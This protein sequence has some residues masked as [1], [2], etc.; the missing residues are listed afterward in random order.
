MLDSNG[1]IV[2]RFDVTVGEGDGAALIESDEKIIEVV[3]LDSTLASR[4]LSL[5]D[6]RHS[7]GDISSATAMRADEVRVISDALIENG[8]AVSAGDPDAPIDHS[9][10]AALA[11]R[12]YP[13]WKRRLFG[14]GLWRSL[15][16]G[17]ATFAQ[18]AG[19]LLENY[20]LIEGV[21]ARL[22]SATAYCNTREARRLFSHHYREEFDHGHFFLDALQKIGIPREQADASLPLPSTRA[23][24][25]HM[26]R[27]AR[28]DSLQ[29]A[30]CSAFLESTGG[31]RVNARGFFA[32]ITERF[33]PNRPDIVAP[34][35]AHLE[36]DEDYGHNG[37]LERMCPLLAPISGA[38]ASAALEAAR[39]LV[40]TLELWSADIARHYADSDA[41][42]RAGPYRR[43]RRPPL[44]VST[45]D[46][47]G[48]I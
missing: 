31:D 41:L 15:V 22:G 4:L 3:G 24:I 44:A 23:V 34:L 28:V 2:V 38:R 32:A 47:E 18:F 27:C 8:M 9:A 45:S 46:I 30:A 20:H 37:I 7:L 19:W 21:N 43:Y 48:V 11:R 40:E 10:F 33:A 16:D 13:S 26:R 12:L 1:R 35:V 39:M 42:P 25:N 36:L 29:Y 5:M 6:G 14:H 17:S